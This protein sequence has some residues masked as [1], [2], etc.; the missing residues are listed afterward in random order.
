MKL[1]SASK[2]EPSLDEVILTVWVKQNH[3]L[4]Q[5]KSSFCFYKGK[6]A[7]FIAARHAD[8]DSLFW[9]QKFHFRTLTMKTERGFSNVSNNRLFAEALYPAP[10]Q[11][12]GLQPCTASKHTLPPARSQRQW[13]QKG[14]VHYERVPLSEPG[15]YINAV[16][17]QVKRLHS[18]N[19]APVYTGVW[20]HDR[21]SASRSAWQLSA[22]THAEYLQNWSHDC[23]KGANTLGLQKCCERIWELWYWV[24]RTFAW[25]QTESL[26]CKDRK[27]RPGRNSSSIQVLVKNSS[28]R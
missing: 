28:K 25:S 7:L 9:H 12:H 8:C 11:S 5:K 22:A 3:F 10:T 23:K 4:P 16:K 13:H 26:Q 27:R 6:K 21:T 20:R 24:L 15:V 18:N 17:Q 2:E 1:V 14:G 19:E